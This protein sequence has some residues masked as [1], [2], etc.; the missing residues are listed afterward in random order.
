MRSFCHGNQ[1]KVEI[2]SYIET[3]LVRDGIAHLPGQ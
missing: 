2:S 1:L 3:R